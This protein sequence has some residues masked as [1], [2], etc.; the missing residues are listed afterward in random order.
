M[1]ANEFIIDKEALSV[2]VNRLFK[3]PLTEVWDAFT[4]KEILD[5]WWAPKPWVCKTK[6]QDFINGGRWLYAMVGPE[7]QEHWAFAEYKDINTK[8]GFGFEDG[9]CNAEGVKNTELPTSEWKLDFNEEDEYITR[10]SI[11]IQQ[12]SLEDLDN[13]LAMGFKEG[14]EATLKSLTAL[15]E[16]K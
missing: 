5:T 6:Q 11:V 4:K 14:F 8:K 1:K 3:V 16:G 2:K 10:L 7:N 13:I 9:F 12:Q 15:L